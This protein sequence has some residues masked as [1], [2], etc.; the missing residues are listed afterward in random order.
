MG[1][2]HCTPAEIKEFVKLYEKYGTYAAVAKEAKRS[3]GAVSKH[4]KLYYAANLADVT[5]AEPKQ[6]II[7]L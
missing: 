7:N 2:K 1:A 5:S 4:I 3:V 6:I